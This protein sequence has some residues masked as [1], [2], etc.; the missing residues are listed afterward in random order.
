MKIRQIIILILFTFLN[1]HKTFGNDNTK[2]LSCILNGTDYYD[3]IVKIQQIVT[4]S[5][6]MKSNDINNINSDHNHLTDTAGTE[7]HLNINEWNKEYKITDGEIRISLNSVKKPTF[8]YLHFG[9]LEIHISRYTGIS[10]MSA[11]YLMDWKKNGTFVR[12]GYVVS[13]QCKARKQQF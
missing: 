7:G 2:I 13:G 4:L 11:S 1:S 6:D 12:E 5:V 10:K 8:K 3:N 9:S